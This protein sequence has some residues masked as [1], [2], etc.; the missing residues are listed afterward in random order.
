LELSK[1]KK[2]IIIQTAVPDYRK[3]F[4]KALRDNL[5]DNFELYSGSHYF[6]KSIQSD[7]TIPHK[8][9]KNTYL[10]NARFLIQFEV[11]K[12]IASDNLLV[13][14]LNPRII[15]NWILLIG[16][17][18]VGKQTILWGHAWPRQGKDAS[19]DTLRQLM[20]KLASAIVVYTNKQ[21]LE[22]QERMPHKTILAAPNALL[23][24]SQM[25]ATAGNPKH[26][27][28]VG[29]LTK[30]KKALFLAKAFSNTLDYIPNDVQLL[31]I[32]DGE[33]KAALETFIIEN[34]LAQRIQL[35]GHIS[36][37]SRLR[38]L[39]GTSYFSVSPGYVGLSI[40]QSFGFG[41]PMIVSR[42]E[43][44]SPEI[45]AV[46]DGENAIFFETDSELS[47]RESLLNIYN[48]TNFWL[49][50]R[51]EIAT[52]CAENYSVEAMARVFCKLLKTY[53]A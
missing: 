16:R 1:D 14:E 35:L 24:K 34:S 38:E 26:L 41:V 22:L 40:T 39:Y 25:G 19:T 36:D 5:G 20:R 46:L 23:N 12:L 13:L 9:T 50:K 28:Y 52:F 30:S 15:S 32:G 4:F 27:I 8:K 7:A 31:I 37:E 51:D 29:R 6:E 45:E 42:D 18:I 43:D 49:S 47:F 11:I 48:D 21:R 53:R 10:F 2:L 3:G 33:E 44:H 17:K